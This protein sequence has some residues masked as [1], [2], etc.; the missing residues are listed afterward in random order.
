MTAMPEARLPPGAASNVKGKIVY[1]YAEGNRLAQQRY[2]D[3][4]G[5]QDGRLEYAWK[6]GRIAEE[7]V[8]RADGR[9]ERRL[10]YGYGPD[11][12]LVSRA[13]A[14]AS[15]ITREIVRY[16]NAYRVETRTVVY[17]E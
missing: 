4:T 11:G 6:D 2:F 13:L 12:A 5:A 1:V 3:A 7:S 17:Y 15:G 10:S 8:Y 16:E 9:L 14:D